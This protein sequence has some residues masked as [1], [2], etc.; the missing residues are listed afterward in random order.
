M[1][2]V[3]QTIRAGMQPGET[4]DTLSYGAQFRL[5]KIDDRGIVLDLAMRHPTRISWQSLDGIVPLLRGRGWVRSG[6]VHS[7]AGQPGTLHEYLQANGPKRDVTNWVATILWEA[8]IA[9]AQ[10]GPP[11]MIRLAP[12]SQWGRLTVHP[13]Q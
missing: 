10:I 5:S 6:G 1:G 7:T 3:E 13:L 11:L 8:G 12:T 4:F 9:E 2:P